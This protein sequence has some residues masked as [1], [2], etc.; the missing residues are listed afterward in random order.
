MQKWELLRWREGASKPGEGCC[1]GQRG[2]EVKIRAFLEVELSQLACAGH[3]HYPTCNDTTS[4]FVCT[5]RAQPR[6]G[7]QWDEQ[8][9]ETKQ[10]L[11]WWL[12][13]QRSATGDS[14]G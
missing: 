6:F 5:E 9:K 2:S 12:C 7:Q 8:H 4:G 3:T 1:N 14:S 13:R 11:C 10:E